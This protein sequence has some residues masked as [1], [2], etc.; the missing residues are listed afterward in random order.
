MALVKPWGST[1]ELLKS[2]AVG[3]LDGK[4]G[5]E[6]FRFPQ[7]RKRGG[8][9]KIES[10]EGSCRCRFQHENP[11]QNESGNRTFLRRPLKKG[12]PSEEN[13]RL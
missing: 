6:F 1:Q 4:P 3:Q 2:A 13:Q 12:Q 9:E 10:S 11:Q 7:I 5:L 8:A